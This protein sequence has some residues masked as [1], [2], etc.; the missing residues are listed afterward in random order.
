MNKSAI[1]HLVH[2][3]TLYLFKKYLLRTQYISSA[4]D[5][6]RCNLIKPWPFMGFM[7]KRE[8]YKGQANNTKH[9]VI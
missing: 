4:G 2:C 3:V 6:G 8:R 1:Q 9:K 7:F 5:T